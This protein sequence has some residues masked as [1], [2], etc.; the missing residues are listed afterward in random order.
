MDRPRIKQTTERI[1]SPDGDLYLMRPSSSGDICIESPTDEELRLVEALDGTRTQEE[2]ELEFGSE[3]VIDALAQFE[4]MGLLEDAADDDRIAPEIYA[5]FARQLRY[6]AD[7]PPGP[8]PSECQAA[9]ENARVAVL[10][11]GGLGGWSAL[12]LAC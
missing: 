3:E 6:F 8:T 5:R 9:L 2:L 11:V 1:R 4:E 10:G 12:S 7:I